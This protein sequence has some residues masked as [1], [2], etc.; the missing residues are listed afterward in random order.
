MRYLMDIHAYDVMTDVTIAARVIDASNSSDTYR[1]VFSTVLCM[2]GT[3]EDDP[4][5]WL[6]DALIY[7]LEEL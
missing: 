7:L 3:G 6:R 2:P 5:Q 1:T 4:R